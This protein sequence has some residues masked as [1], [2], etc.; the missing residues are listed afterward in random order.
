[1]GSRE[2]YAVP[3][4]FQREGA[5]RR[6]YTDAW[7]RG[8]HSLLLRGPMDARSYAGRY[9]PGVP[10]DKVVSFTGSAI[11]RRLHRSLI[12]RP[13]TYDEVVLADQRYGSWFCSRVR[14]ELRRL[15]IDPARDCFFG[16]VSESLEALEWLAGRGVVTVVDQTAPGPHGD[17]LVRAEMRRWPDW[18][19]S[20]DV[21]PEPFYDRLRAEWK[22]ASIVLVNS[23]FTFRSLQTQ[24]VEPERMVVVPLAYEPEADVSRP[25]A[26]VA[27]AGPLTVL[28]M[29]S[30]TVRK[31][32]QYLIEAARLL[33]DT[34]VRF[35][36]VGSIAI[37]EDA[38]RSATP[39]VRFVGRVS[40][41][42]A[43]DYYRQAD[44][45]ALPTVADGFAITQL[46]AMGH[47]VP[48][49]ATSNCGDVVT[50][51]RD[52]LLVPA[53]DGEALA[54]AIARLDGD[55]RLLAELASHTVEKSRQFTLQRYADTV[56][57]AVQRARTGASAVSPES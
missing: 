12:V 51:E 46:E 20:G 3:R 31:G 57:R 47:G 48:V 50:H 9:H 16:F 41:D 36:V 15:P 8:G 54:S 49:I 38:V 32:I 11:L 5:L 22:A 6:F 33:K 42:Q 26:T 24:G 53:S 55:R 29:G 44:V 1:V 21:S 27:A 19:I 4:V 52:G 25:A 2:H 17:E 39:N 7:A 35:L 18:A 23:G 34:D 30:V 56:R 37:S 28:W 45:F 40:R 13:R 43:A 10:S 14:D